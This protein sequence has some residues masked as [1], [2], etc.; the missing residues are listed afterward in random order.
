[1][2]AYHGVGGL[3]EEGAHEKIPYIRLRCK[4]R[5]F[6][7]FCTGLCPPELFQ[8]GI[9]VFIIALFCFQLDA[10]VCP[11]FCAVG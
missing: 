8:T 2:F 11:L 3:L 6:L 5:G 10:H 9:K 4:F 1:M 7:G